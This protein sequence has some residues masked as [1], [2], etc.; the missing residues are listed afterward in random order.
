MLFGFIITS[1][2]KPDDK[3]SS[4]NTDDDTAAEAEIFPSAV[5][6]LSGARQ[7]VT[8]NSTGELTYISYSLSGLLYETWE[9]LGSGKSKVTK[10][11]SSTISAGGSST[12]IDCTDNLIFEITLSKTG[13]NLGA[14]LLD[15]GCGSS[16]I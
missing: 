8:T 10:W 9:W 12:T 7:V 3:S 5:Y 1:C 4:S 14:T 16:T 13:K 6:Y 2:A 15:D 11:G